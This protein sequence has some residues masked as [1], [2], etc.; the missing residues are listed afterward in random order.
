MK[1][2][3]LHLKGFT[4]IRRGMKVDEIA[5]DMESL[6]GTAAL[7]ALVGTNGAGKT[8]IMDNLHPYRL[9]PSRATSY[10]VGGFS[11]YDHICLPESAK[12]LTW[13]H[14]GKRYRSQLIFRV[15]GVRKTE[16]FLHVW[17]GGQWHVVILPDGT[18]SDG[19]TDTYDRCV[20]HILGSAETFFTSQFGAQNRR[21]LSAYK[22][23]EI[24]SLMVELLMLKQIREAGERASEVAKLLRVALEERQGRRRDL[25]AAKAALEQD[26]QAKDTIQI[27]VIDADANRAKAAKALDAQ[28]GVLLKIHAE[29]DGARANE[30][31][32][33]RL[34][35]RLADTL[36]EAD[37]TL[38]QLE[39][40]NSKLTSDGNRLAQNLTVARSQAAQQLAARKTEQ[41]KAQA[42]LEKRPDIEAAVE[43][44]RGMDQEE[45]SLHQ[46]FDQARTAHAK[47]VALRQEEQLLITERAG[48]EREAGSAALRENGLK[49]RLG[50]TVEVPCQG[51]D[52]QD[53]CKLLGDAHEAKVL[54]PS[55]AAEI[56]AI[57]AKL[58][59][60]DKALSILRE[61]LAGLE[62]T[63]K[64][65]QQ[66]DQALLDFG[67]RQQA[68][69]AR[70]ALK[71]SLDDADE[72]VAR[73][74]EEQAQISAKLAA[75]E[76]QFVADQQSNE[77]QL[78]SLSDRIKELKLRRDT[79]MMAI[80]DELAGLPPAFDSALQQRAEVALREAENLASTFEAAYLNA[81]RA[82]ASIASRIETLEAGIR[83][84]EAGLADT[85]ALESEVAWWNLLA[86]ALSPD[87]VIA[88]CI[89][90]AGPTLSRIT[91]DL[92]L[93]CYGARFTVAITTQ[94]ETAKKD[95]RE[96]FD[97]I[98]FDAESGDSQ[99]VTLMS[100]GEK[101]WINECLTRAISI[102]L[103]QASGRQ[104]QTVFSDETDGPLDEDRKRMFI[105]MKREALRL[106]GYELEIFVSHTP[107]LWAMADLVIDVS[108]LGTCAQ[109][110]Q[111]AQV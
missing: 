104:Y 84:A 85:A 12:D 75:D 49:A 95:V 30:E 72:R 61:E 3:K 4:G 22:T 11:Y 90:D 91:N 37:K 102:Y 29:R 111:Y 34:N 103:A 107:E 6:V 64:I 45:A 66:A 53:R 13:E 51:T 42:L 38:K 73:L 77:A 58:D 86:K 79:S 7:V 88:L 5:L 40:E 26:L 65:V 24:K 98:V 41:Q 57:Q 35:Q 44:M 83:Q 15:N 99:S 67:K 28:R 2:I 96:G 8:T 33:A 31:R 10:S 59:E 16:A 109:A 92:L 89:D 19:K 27:E 105:N 32:R 25:D 55:A 60:L 54:M 93:S 47:F 100:G 20:E 74:A 97:I 80:R 106:G 43:A 76:A 108:Q 17:D 23:G 48:L 39:T 82:Q 62:Q 81:V 21:P 1:P 63:D 70:A 18:R 14:E 87:G 94:V 71:P 68:T 56:I 50:L 52:L 78:A 101:V 69:A 36:E 9:M 110:G 46:R